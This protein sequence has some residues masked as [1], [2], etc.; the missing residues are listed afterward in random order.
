MGNQPWPQFQNGIR[1]RS[2]LCFS[3]GFTGPGSSAS[4]NSFTYS[5]VSQYRI[6]S[7]IFTELQQI[8]K[9]LKIETEKM[10]LENFNLCG[11]SKYFFRA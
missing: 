1:E 3:A 4:H 11:V 2:V 8:V 10:N 9:I 7:L 6:E 5:F